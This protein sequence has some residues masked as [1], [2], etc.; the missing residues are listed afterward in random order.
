MPELLNALPSRKSMLW[1]DT[2]PLSSTFHEDPLFLIADICSPNAAADLPTK[3]A[4]KRRDRSG[5]VLMKRLVVAVSILVVLGTAGCGAAAVTTTTGATSLETTTSVGQLV[6]FNANLSGQDEVPPVK[7]SATGL[8]TFTLD[9]SGTVVA[10]ALNVGMLDSPTVAKVHL[11]RAGTNG[12]TILTL[13]PGPTK[14]VM[15]NGTLAQGSFD[16]T[17]LQGSLKGK[18]IADLVTLIKAGEVYL[19]VGT[20]KHRGGEIRGQFG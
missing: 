20:V 1:P 4:V 12:E 8:A 3:A 5:G 6:T 19:N 13:Y 10:Y 16:A 9:S 11:G 2:D 17:K 18:T 14:K 15:I 7:S